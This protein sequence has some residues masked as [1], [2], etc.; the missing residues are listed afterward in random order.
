[1]LLNTGMNF[2]AKNLIHIF[3]NNSAELNKI[4]NKIMDEIIERAL[5]Y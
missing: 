3:K 4:N 2:T 5:K 1:M